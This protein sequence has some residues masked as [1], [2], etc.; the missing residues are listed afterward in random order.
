MPSHTRPSRF[1]CECSKTGGGFGTRLIR[2]DFVFFCREEHCPIFCVQ[3]QSII[4]IPIFFVICPLQAQESSRLRSLA[5][6]DLFL[7]SARAQLKTLMTD[8]SLPDTAPATSCALF[9]STSTSS[10]LSQLQP[11]GT[12]DSLLMVPD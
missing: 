12:T 10:E 8:S 7:E 1:S 4:T 6:L 9:A 5:S 3:S 2:D 11:G